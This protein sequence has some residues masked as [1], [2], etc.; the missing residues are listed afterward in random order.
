MCLNDGHAMKTNLE[1]VWSVMDVMNMIF[2]FNNK[3]AFM[4]ASALGYKDTRRRLG[5]SI[6]NMS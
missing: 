6:K 5:V 3:E 1:S 4:V 2:D